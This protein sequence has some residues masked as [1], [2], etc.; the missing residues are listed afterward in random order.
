MTRCIL[1][2]W[3]VF[4]LL[5]LS[6]SAAAQEAG[7]PFE[8]KSLEE[9]ERLIKE[10]ME[11]RKKDREIAS[12]FK[13]Y[14]KREEA[15]LIR[16]GRGLASAAYA[17]G[18]YM[19]GEYLFRFG[20]YAKSLDLL[21]QCEKKNRKNRRQ[22]RALLN[23]VHLLMAADYTY[24]DE[25][26]KAGASIRQ[27]KADGAFGGMLQEVQK[28]L[29]EFPTRRRE[30]QALKSARDLAPTGGKV[31]GD[32]QWALCAFY[33]KS[34]FLPVEEY[35][36]LSWMEETFPDHPQVRSGEAAWSL[37]RCSEKLLDDREVIQRGE[38]FRKSYPNHW[39]S[40]QGDL[41][42]SL[43]KAYY[44]KGALKDARRTAELLKQKHPKFPN[45]ES[46]E[47]DSLIADCDKGIPKDRFSHGNPWN[48]WYKW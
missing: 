7:D 27:A 18:E 38:K 32:H 44:G 2:S 1:G 39:A 37:V 24:L 28:K 12:S 40:T 15:K 21:I 11:E 14:F 46:K 45:V 42:W 20:E 35:V 34:I 13:S 5:G 33:G 16:S 43:A 10:R 26:T 48:Q 4:V 19:Q 3:A 31:R 9:I 25:P 8:G 36:E 29:V 23:Q 47:V 30:L 17:S 6:L 22:N 41:L